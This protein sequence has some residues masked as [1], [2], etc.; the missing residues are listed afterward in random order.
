MSRFIS[1]FGLP[2]PPE[3]TP[4]QY[5]RTAYYGGRN[6]F[7]RLNIGR[8][9]AA[10]AGIEVAGVAASLITSQPA[11]AGVAVGLDA[12]VAGTTW[13]NLHVYRKEPARLIPW[14]NR[15]FARDVNLEQ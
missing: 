12:L 14:I 1:A 11:F 15:I 13:H 3:Q 10:L 5:N 6:V 4:S 2:L 8:L 9:A 7:T